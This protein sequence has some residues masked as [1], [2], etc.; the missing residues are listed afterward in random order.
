MPN[1]TISPNMNMPVP[2]VST[3]PGPDWAT[4]IDACLSIV[5]SHNHSAGMGVQINPSGIDINS[6]FPMN[7]NN[8]TESRSLRF[9]PQSS[10]ISNSAD[11]GCLYELGVDLYY[12]DGSGNNVRMTQGGAV[13]GSAGTITGLPSGTASA[14]FAA[15]TFTWQSATNTAA[16]MSQGP[17]KISQAVASG[18]GVTI[19]ANG[20]Q[21]ADYSL[22]LPLALPTIQSTIISD[23]SGNLSFT[24]FASG[25]YNPTV[26]TGGFG[27]GQAAVGPF[28]YQRIGNIVTVAGS[29]TCSF[30]GST[31]LSW[32]VTLPI[33]PSA[34]FSNTYDVSGV[35]GSLNITGHNAQETVLEGRVGFNQIEGFLQLDGNSAIT[36]TVS[37]RFTY[38]C[39]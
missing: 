9:E 24:G 21:A 14:S 1:T 27:T 36:T 18:K 38:S 10:A 2:V 34:V 26:V 29:L 19:S 35:L 6:D 33:N 23:T 13:A 11:L 39:A 20:S 30:N 8:I 32:F 4:N 15:G 17:T 22:T 7:A 12:K 16:T 31:T 5:D 25:T 37:A 3:D 28:F